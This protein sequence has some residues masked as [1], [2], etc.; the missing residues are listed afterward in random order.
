MTAIDRVCAAAGTWCSANDGGGSNAYFLGFAG[1]THGFLAALAGGLAGAARFFGAFVGAGCIPV[2]RGVR[3]ARAI[4][5]Y[6]GHVRP[7]MALQSAA[8]FSGSI[9]L[10]AARSTRAP[11]AFE[12]TPAAPGTFERAGGSSAM[13]RGFTPTRRQHSRCTTWRGHLSVSAARFRFS[14]RSLGAS[15]FTQRQ[16]CEQHRRSRELT[17]SAKQSK[18]P[19][20]VV[21]IALLQI[22]QVIWQVIFLRTRRRIQALVC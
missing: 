17:M 22:R 12:R 2:A 15:W 14:T 20:S 8:A 11:A 6:G 5:G 4:H 9:F 1:S 21:A 13:R 16:A 19:S 3:Q 10:G 7:M 18:S